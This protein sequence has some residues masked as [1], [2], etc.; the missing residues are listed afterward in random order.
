MRVLPVHYKY[1]IH[2]KQVYLK[3]LLSLPEIKLKK[4]PN[5]LI[6]ENCYCFGTTTKVAVKDIKVQYKTA[7]IFVVADR[8]DYTYR[9]IDGVEAVFCGEY[10]NDC[11]KLSEIQCK[12]LG[13]DP[14]QYYYPWESLDEEIAACQLKQYEYV[15]LGAAE[16]RA[17]VVE[18]F[19]FSK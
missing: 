7:R 12:K 4:Y 19:D 16:K 2:D 8:M 3:R 14:T 5:I 13:I 15:D 9:E 11:K 6:A 1:F 17:K 18:H 10:N